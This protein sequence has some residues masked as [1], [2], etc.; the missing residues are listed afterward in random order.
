LRDKF[1]VFTHRFIVIDAETDS[2]IIY[3]GSAN[4]SNNSVHKNDENL[5]EIKGSIESAALYLCD[6]V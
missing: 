4:M 2:P 1:P 6:D 5:L 3:T